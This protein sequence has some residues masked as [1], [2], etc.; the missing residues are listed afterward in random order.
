ML[1]FTR[2]RNE[3]VVIDQ[4]IVIT[5]VEITGDRIR[6]GIE[7][8]REVP[9]HRREVYDAIHAAPVPEQTDSAN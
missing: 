1:V 3:Q 9:V 5:V 8:P 2:K 7:A 4:N 6:L